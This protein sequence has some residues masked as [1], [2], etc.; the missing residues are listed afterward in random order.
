[1]K[2]IVSTRYGPPE[3]LRLKK[4]RTP[5]PNDHEV[6]IKIRATTVTSTDCNARN[7]TFVPAPMRLPVRLFM[8]GA[9]RP[10]IRIPGVDLTGEVEAVG[11]EVTR[12]KEGDQVFG[13]PGAAR[14]GAHA[15]YLCMPEDGVLATK[16]ANLG[17]DE[18][19]CIPL[20]ANKGQRRPERGPRGRL[21][22]GG[23]E[24]FEGA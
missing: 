2:A 17:W 5:S 12:F 10:K 16:P 14:S 23:C 7:L 21:E 11:G 20:A 1:M 22:T 19:A 9:F 24:H 13:T 4:V 18:A 15:E 8:V 6:L 3:V